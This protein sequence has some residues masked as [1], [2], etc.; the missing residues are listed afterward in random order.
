MMPAAPGPAAEAV[1]GH[2][3]PAAAPG[4]PADPLIAALFD[5]AL[6]VAL[7]EIDASR[8]PSDEAPEAMSAVTVAVAPLRDGPFSDS[9]ARHDE[10]PADPWLAIAAWRGELPPQPM[11]VLAP[12]ASDPTTTSGGA[13]DARTATPCAEFRLDAHGADAADRRGLH[14]GD[15]SIE[16]A[17]AHVTPGAATTAV[18]AD[19]GLGPPPSASPPAT[20]APAFA[21][22][23]RQATR[24]I[25][26]VAPAAIAPAP[27]PWVAAPATASIAAPIDSPGFAPALADHV[28]RL[29]TLKMDHLELAVHPAELGP[30]VLSVAVNGSDVQV[31]VMAVLPEARTALEQSLPDLRSLLQGAGITL[32]EASVQDGRASRDDARAPA[33]DARE[34]PADD[35]PAAVAPLRRGLVDLYA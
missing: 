1:R 9:V 20:A 3:P 7:G 30:V 31:V 13:A 33:S 19:P 23:E 32:G 11:P 28:A 5:A 27:A 17:T 15:R 35:A 12:S 29:V 18:Q 2:A 10:A 21:G 16:R 14:A 34:S 26:D 4:A 24:T 8:A 6:E 25:G 22:D